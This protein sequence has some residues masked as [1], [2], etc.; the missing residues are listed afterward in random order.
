MIMT[1]STT[2]R[3]YTLLVDMSPAVY[4]VENTSMVSKIKPLNILSE[5]T[6]MIHQFKGNTSYRP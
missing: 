3:S 1:A 5:K 4:S 6:A 2:Q